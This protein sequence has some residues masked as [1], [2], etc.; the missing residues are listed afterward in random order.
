MPVRPGYGGYC[1]TTIRIPIVKKIITE[2]LTM[3]GGAAISLIQA[4]WG[5]VNSI[6]L[7]KHEIKAARKRFEVLLMDTK[8]V[9]AFR[10]QLSVNLKEEE[11]ET[12]DFLDRALAD[13]EELCET[14]RKLLMEKSG[15]GGRS[16]PTN[17]KRQ[18]ADVDIPLKDLVIWV[19][20]SREIFRLYEA[21]LAPD[22]M[23]SLRDWKEDL[24]G[25]TNDWDRRAAGMQRD[26]AERIRRSR[27]IAMFIR[28]LLFTPE[29]PRDMVGA[30]Q[31]AVG[32]VAGEL[33][34]AGGLPMNMTTA[35]WLRM[36]FLARE[37][38]SWVG[39]VLSSQ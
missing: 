29:L 22:T 19:L 16:K 31:A 27:E 8:A 32:G 23:R 33:S 26:G 12:L 36:R 1:N 34:T 6:R 14:Y 17:P 39:Q 11:P 3:D 28:Q 7:A 24:R 5:G 35:M 30:Y 20:K 15:K 4:I 9:R 25:R 37:E 13:A 10:D 21:Q 2:S 38:S 18:R